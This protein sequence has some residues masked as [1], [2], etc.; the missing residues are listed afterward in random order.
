MNMWAEVCCPAEDCTVQLWLWAVQCSGDR[1]S[2]A[3]LAMIM[4]GVPC[5]AVF[6]WAGCILFYPVDNCRRR[7]TWKFFVNERGC[8][9]I[10]MFKDYYCSGACGGS[11]ENC[12]RATRYYLHRY[13][14]MQCEGDHSY[15]DHDF[16]NQISECSCATCEEESGEGINLGE[17]GS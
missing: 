2:Y 13:I 14:P 11:D 7:S 1:V 10:K 16:P 12:C 17:Q 3:M 8:R 15:R 5:L 6:M 4:R 9:S